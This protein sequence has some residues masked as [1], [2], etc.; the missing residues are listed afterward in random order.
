M[1][2]KRVLILEDDSSLCELIR[3]KLKKNGFGC[4]CCNLAED[5]LQLLLKDRDQLLIAD[6]LLP[7]YNADK[8]V[9]KLRSFGLEIP[10][11]VMTGITD[12]KMAVKMMKQGAVDFVVKSVGFT[13][14][15]PAVVEKVF[16]GIIIKKSIEEKEEKIKNSEQKLRF[17][18][19]NIQDIFFILNEKGF[20]AE[21]SPSVYQVLGYTQEEITGKRIKKYFVS[22]S[23]YKF[24]FN[25]LR[26]K[27]AIYSQ[28]IFFK[29]KNDQ[30]I[31]LSVT[32]NV[33]V[34][35][36]DEIQTLGFAQN[37]STKAITDAE[38][39]KR[40]LEAEETERK[41]M[42]VALHDDVGPLMSV[43]KMYFQLLN[44]VGEDELK[45]KKLLGKVSEI[46]DNTI[47]K[48][49]NIS[50]N[51]TANLLELYDLKESVNSFINKIRHVTSIEFSTEI[52]CYSINKTTV[53]FLYRAI[54][55]LI[56]NAIKH[57]DAKTVS[58]EVIQSE[59][60]LLLSYSDDGRGFDP[61]LL[62]NPSLLK[63]NGLLSIINRVQMLSGIC[64]IITSPGKGLQVNI[65]FDNKLI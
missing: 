22:K 42:A 23:K 15:L 59:N 39:I 56:N 44:D 25:D 18:F 6:F 1:E 3:I 41:K 11:I 19:E 8:L 46:I 7:D 65:I 28:K 27:G 50:D 37:I 47:E 17:F 61:E 45:R 33:I 21:I 64:Q 43:L 10:F 38:I 14:T 63:G 62:K 53:T 31:L 49:R 29:Q 48:I 55:E 40:T 2:S 60:D 58:L 51:L 32:C 57:S 5:A 54:Q 16:A 9:E 52:N 12:Q 20:I 26:E 24:L 35:R 4:T 36:N 30:Q 34:N 13:D